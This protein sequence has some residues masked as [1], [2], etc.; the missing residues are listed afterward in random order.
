M[1]PGRAPLDE[2][3]TPTA[4]DEPAARFCAKIAAAGVCA[5]FARPTVDAMQVP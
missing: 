3:A 4:I 5:R 2:A 1:R